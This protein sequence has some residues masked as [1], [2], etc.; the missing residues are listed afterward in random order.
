MCRLDDAEEDVTIAIIDEMFGFS[1]D[2][3]LRNIKET[4]FNDSLFYFAVIF[5]PQ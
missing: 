5:V 4:V 1:N 2:P 3:R